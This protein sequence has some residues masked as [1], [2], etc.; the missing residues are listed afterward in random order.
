MAIALQEVVNHTRLRH[1]VFNREVIPTVSLA[2]ILS[3]YQRELI[4]LAAERNYA[5]V[6]DRFSVA[7]DFGQTSPATL[8]M[9]ALNFGAV[10]GVPSFDSETGSGVKLDTLGN[11]VPDTT[12]VLTVQFG[13]GLVMPPLY[14]IIG[15]DALYA[16]SGSSGSNDPSSSPVFIGTRYGSD[17]KIVAYDQRNNP[18]VFPSG[19]LLGDKLY[20]CGTTEDWSG[21][22]SLDVRYVPYPPNLV[23]VN[24]TFRIGELGRD[25]LNARADL[26]AAEWAVA[27]KREGVDLQQ[28]LS[29][30]REA[31]EKFLDAASG[32]QSMLV[33]TTKRN[34]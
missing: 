26:A 5:L 32:R 31:E 30:K 15:G 19:Y 24:D 29:D 12:R 16:G 28:F 3:D 10:T 21:Y 14:K 17:F 8:L 20:L 1:P 25:A 18:P 11:T 2:S 4:K 23:T 7:F 33:R 9:T 27:R 22:V 13:D 34:R 6:V